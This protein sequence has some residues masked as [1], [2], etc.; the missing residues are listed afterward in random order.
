[1]ISR[2]AEVR[3]PNYIILNFLITKSSDHSLRGGGG[4]VKVHPNYMIIIVCDTLYREGVKV[5]S[6]SR[7]QYILIIYN[8]TI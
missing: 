4:G 6:H 2:E 8:A 3:P 5:P 7:H 1:M